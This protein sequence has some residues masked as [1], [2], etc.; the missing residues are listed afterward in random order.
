[1][2]LYIYLATERSEDMK[3]LEDEIK[4]RLFNFH[5]A[6]IGRTCNMLELTCCLSKDEGDI[7]EVW[8]IQ[9]PFRILYDNH[10]MT[11]DRDMYIPHNKDDETFA[12]YSSKRNSEFDFIVNNKIHF[13]NDIIVTN[14]TI[15][16]YGDASIEMQ[17]NHSVLKVECFNNASADD[18]EI[19]RFFRHRSAIPHIVC[20]K[21]N[22][23]KE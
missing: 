20:Y 14:V 11:S 17:Y 2:K 10:I 7:S 22:I 15:S 5:L 12:Y 1:M 9:S 3:L 19:W 4:K 8:H 6:K 13:I 21:N 23:V 18:D 16:P